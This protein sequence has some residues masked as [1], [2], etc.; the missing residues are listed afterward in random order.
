MMSAG[1]MPL[2]TEPTVDASSS[3][4]GLAQH[5]GSSMKPGARLEIW[6]LWEKLGELECKVLTETCLEFHARGRFLGRAFD[7]SGKIELEPRG[8]CTIEIGQ[9]RD[10]E[11]RYCL[12]HRRPIVIS[13]DCN[14][15]APSLRF[16][17]DGVE[18]RAEL[19]CTVGKLRPKFDLTIAPPS[20]TR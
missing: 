20:S 16:W 8:H 18:T 11:A 14:G 12:E 19:R 7:A 6:L 4:T 1:F 10:P 2:A 15:H 3:C 17:A 13:E 9:L 5:V